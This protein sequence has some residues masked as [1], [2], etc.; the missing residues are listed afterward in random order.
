MPNP[1]SKSWNYLKASLDKKVDDNADP[2]ILVRQAMDNARQQHKA[3]T[4][5]AASVIG[6]AKQ[7]EIAMGTKSRQLDEVQ[8]QIRQT[9]QVAESARAEG[10]TARAGQF[11]AQAEQLASKM[12]TLEQ[13]LENTKQLHGQAVQAAEQAKQAVKESDQR[14][15]ET[16]AQEDQLLLQATQAEMQ[17]RTVDSVSSL[18][19]VGGGNSPTFDEIRAKIEGRY[20]TALGKQELAEA[21]GAPSTAQLDAAAFTRESEGKSKLEQIRASM[22][23]TGGGTAV[24]GAGPGADSDRQLPEG[25][26]TDEDT[27]TSGATEAA[28]P[29]EQAGSPSAPVDDSGTPEPGPADLAGPTLPRDTRD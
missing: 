18:E 9:L 28:T 15:R 4:D 11:E 10:D 20:T 2:K 21:T 26:G 5:Q 16:L 27:G 19:G 12:V 17:H 13:D 3:V 22:G 23:L 24:E 8:G 14:L 6:N 7:L 29:T 1:F 25:A